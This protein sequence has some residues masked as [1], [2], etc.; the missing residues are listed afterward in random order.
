MFKTAI[1]TYLL[2]LTTLTSTANVTS[3]QDLQSL[4]QQ[5]SESAVVF[6]GDS[7]TVGMKTSMY[8]VIDKDNEFFIAESGQG[9]SWLKSTGI[10]NLKTTISSHA[11]INDWTI[12][13]NL[14]INDLDDVD[15]YVASYKKVISELD[16]PNCSVTLYVVSVNPVDETKCKSVT[17]SEIDSINDI[18]AKSFDDYNNIRYIDS[19]TYAKKILSTTDGLHY[20][21]GT[22]RSIYIYILKSITGWENS[23]NVLS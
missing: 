18:F 19:N 13:T 4:K 2:T 22:Y 6:L 7:R 3:S 8:N 16:T 14:G 21:D 10:P 9:Y 15:K 1:F 20:T 12:V 5:S 23:L 17:N 11:K